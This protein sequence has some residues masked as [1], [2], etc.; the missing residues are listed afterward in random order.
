[1]KKIF[2]VIAALAI[3]CGGLFLGF[4][5]AK[6][7]SPSAPQVAPMPGYFQVIVNVQATVDRECLESCLS[8]VAL[9]TSGG[10]I[11]FQPFVYGTWEYYFWV[12]APF[13]GTLIAVVTSTQNCG[14]NLLIGE[15]SASGSWF[16]NSPPVPL[17]V[18][19]N[20]L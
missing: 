14:C 12:R 10:S 11:Q 5:S 8:N 13:T 1:M 6:A 2:L 20:Y 9:W 15:G 17:I 16:D 7:D 19:I 18:T 4:R 3:V